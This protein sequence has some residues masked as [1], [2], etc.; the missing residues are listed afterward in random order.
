MKHFLTFFLINLVVASLAHAES[1]KV[2]GVKVSSGISRVSFSLGIPFHGSVV[3]DAQLPLGEGEHWLS[4]DHLIA[5]EDFK[6]I[7]ILVNS[8]GTILGA[9]A[10]FKGS[11]EN[12]RGASGYASRQ[13]ILSP[14]MG[15][16]GPALSSELP[17]A[18][19][20]NGLG[21]IVYTFDLSGNVSWRISQ[22]PTLTDKA[23][24]LADQDEHIPQLKEC[25]CCNLKTAV[26][27]DPSKRKKNDFCEPE[28]SNGDKPK[29]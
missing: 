7:Q 18:Y 17:L 21:D 9:R 10:I 23:I 14:F 6:S 25:R 16:D 20:G 11:M 15:G 13:R 26:Q 4:L 2:V 24:N 1:P 28:P 5:D 29:N 3:L 27:V 8:N 12:W 19:D 22:E